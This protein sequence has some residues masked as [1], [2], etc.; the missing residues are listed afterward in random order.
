MMQR[1]VLTHLKPDQLDDIVDLDRCCFG[2]LWSRDQYQR[3]LDSPNSD[4]LVL[5][6][7]DTGEIFA[8]GCLWAIL[9]EAHI[10][11]VAVHPHR[12][13]QGFGALML[14]GLMQQAV[15]RDLARATLEV[16]VSNQA[17]IGLYEKFGFETAGRRKQYYA[18]TGED[19]L[20]LWKSHLQWP[21][22]QAQL[23]AC[24][25]AIQARLAQTAIELTVIGLT[26]I[27]LTVDL[28]AKVSLDTK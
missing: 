25:A 18:A 19:A 20:I 4:I 3:E 15:Q 26:V 24:F 16:A 23:A 17:A 6:A 1:L 21:A 28:D 7:A 12:Q 11:I 14:W 27:A 22:D 10:T 13:G 5:L 9:D 8:Y 2:Q